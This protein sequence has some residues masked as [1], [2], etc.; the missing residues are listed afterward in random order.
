M[1]IGDIDQVTRNARAQK[2]YRRYIIRIGLI[3]GLIGALA[4]GGAVV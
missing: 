3:I 4:I 1:R 2:T